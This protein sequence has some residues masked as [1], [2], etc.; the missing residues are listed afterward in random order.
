[1]SA[2][3]VALAPVAIVFVVAGCGGGGGD[4][5]AA[6]SQPTPGV[7]SRLSLRADPGGRLRFDRKPLAAKPGRVTIVMDNPSELSHNVALEGPGIETQL[8]EVVAQDGTSKIS[9]TVKPGRYTFFCS[10]PGHREAGMVG[11]LIVR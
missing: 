3:T 9:A 2:R 6:P 1:M 11:T 4:K 5:K 8:G 10:V 7:A